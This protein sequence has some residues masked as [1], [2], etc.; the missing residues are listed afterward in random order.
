[1]KTVPSLPATLCV[2]AFAFLWT[3]PLAA[4]N[5]TA[6]ATADSRERVWRAAP[7]SLEAHRLDGPAPTI[8][9]ILDEDV[10]TGAPVATDFIQMEP[11]EGQPASERTEARVVYGDDAL[12]V[13]FRAYD[14]NPEQI[15]AQ[16]ARRDQDVYSDWVIVAID[17]YFDR[18]TAFQ[19]RVNPLGVRV[20]TYRFD[21]TQEDDSWDAVWDAAAR[22]DAEGWTAEFEIPYSQLRFEAASD[23][24][25]GIEFARQIARRDETSLWAPI[26]R[27]DGAIVSRFGELRGLRGVNH[28]RR[29]E[30]LPYSV[31]RVTRGPGDAANPFYRRNDTYSSAG[32]DVKFG[33]TSNLTLDLTINPDFGQVEADPGQVNLTAF[34]TFF[35]ERRPF[36]VEGAGIFNLRLSQGDGH[37]ANEL[38]FYTRRIGRAPQGFADAAGGYADHD[39]QTTIAGAWKLSGKTASGWSVGLMH[40]V[41]AEEVADVMTGAGERRKSTV[42][43][44]TNYGVARIIKDFRQGRSAIGFVATATNRGKE[45]ADRLSLRSGGYTGGIDLRHRFADD[46]WSADLSFVASHVRGSPEA[47]ELTQRSSAR[48]FQRPDADHV[49]VDPTRTS[50]T[51]WTS[52]FSVAKIAGGFWRVGAGY[53]A[54]S[55]GFEAND[56]GFMRQT[57]MFNPW[58]WGGYHKSTPGEHLLRWN[59][60]VNGWRAYTF[61]GENTGAGGNVNGSLTHR[62]FWSGY[63]GV[64]YNLEAL[65]T[66]ILRGGPLFL[67]EPSWNGWYGVSSD[68][69]RPLRV[70]V[71]GW[72]GTRPETESWNAGVSTD[73]SFRAGG[74][75]RFSVSPSVSFQRE[76]R[77]WVTAVPHAQGDPSYVLAHLDQTTAGITARFDYSFTPDLSLQFYAQPVLASGEYSDFK[78]VADPRGAAYE[79]RIERFAPAYDAQADRYRAD[80]N[81]DGALESFRNPNFNF[82]QFRSNVV[83]RWEYRP[84]SALFLVWSQG[85]DPCALDF[86]QCSR[87]GTFDFGRSFDRVFDARPSNTLL[88]KMSY[89]LSP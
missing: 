81:G 76:D 70:G 66:G 29:L 78:T 36:F 59:V 9:G 61:G 17:S 43:P 56:V 3:A 48:Y 60:N 25:W 31:A 57:D 33:V 16:L 24:T 19:F 74:N 55:P 8:D 63:A 64:G 20:D 79:D 18:R 82:G 44:L 21:D 88:V 85:R 41:T 84:G 51:G 80:L 2:A 38:L 73:V 5:G 52:N 26:S 53:Q 69:R 83:L 37:D 72:W 58:V 40:A 32:A 23:M 50:L 62:S 54:R 34:E 35:Q 89:W 22:V 49:A 1:M 15:V 7:P 39:P 42:E 27:Q 67:R 11:A 13:A 6:G 10:W 46:A 77:Q 75:F 30:I 12:Y 87:S 45:V 14:R 65:S 68:S 86:S 28:S 4:Q 47:I 71:N